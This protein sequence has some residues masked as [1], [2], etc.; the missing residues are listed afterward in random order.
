MIPSN[1]RGLPRLVH[2]RGT[3]WALAGPGR[4]TLPGKIPKERSNV[5]S[6]GQNH[7]E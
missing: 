2:L 1:R 6:S 7:V 3:R 5:L 4:L